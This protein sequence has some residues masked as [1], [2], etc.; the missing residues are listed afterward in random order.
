MATRLCRVLLAGLLV[1][2]AV[3]SCASVVA[4]TPRA[5]N[6]AG[7][8]ERPTSSGKPRPAAE[9]E[10]LIGDLTTVD[11]CSLTDTRELSSFGTATIGV[12]DSLDEC[13]VDIKT[14]TAPVV[15][16][17]GGLDRVTAFPDLAGKKSTDR[18]G[19]LRVVEYDSDDSYCNHLLVFPDGIT[20]S[21]NASVYE[22]SQPR[23]CD[24]VR[25]AMDSAIEA[26]LLDKVDHR[27]YAR[28][29]LGRV[30]PCEL[31]PEQALAAVPGL[32]SVRPK[33]YPGQHN[34]AWTAADNSV[35]LRLMFIAG[36][37][38][39]PVGPGATE[40][41]VAGRGSVLS[42]TPDAGSYT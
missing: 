42:P 17:V 31:M 10:E 23:L 9:A 33:Q 5:A 15:L 20:L 25:A 34:C 14:S 6:G 18:A 32:G 30:D 8:A 3:T 16:Y 19:G 26:V 28:N 2:A 21:V 27:A 37:P 41:Q 4:G 24:A 13:L 35:R 29:S 12:P 36:K 1:L 7:P 39:K 38:P 22:G 40:G 11:P